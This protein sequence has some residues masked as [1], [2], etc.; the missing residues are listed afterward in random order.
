MTYMSDWIF[1][2]YVMNHESV[3]MMKEQDAN[4]KKVLTAYRSPIYQI[5]VHKK[6]FK[7]QKKQYC[8]HK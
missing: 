2:L 5:M 4:K 8:F 6:H 1:S 3:G 7:M